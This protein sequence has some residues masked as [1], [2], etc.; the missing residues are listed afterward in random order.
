MRHAAS[1]PAPAHKHCTLT[2]GQEPLG[3]WDSLA[4][5]PAAPLLLAQPWEK[6]GG[7]EVW[8]SGRGGLGQG[9]SETRFR[10]PLVLAKGVPA[11]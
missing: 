3:A 6:A 7:L 9:P 8:F 2:A 5:T 10:A 11:P 4:R 1:Q